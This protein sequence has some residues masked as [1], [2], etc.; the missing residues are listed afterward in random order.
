MTMGKYQKIAILTAVAIALIVIFAK[1]EFLVNKKY[2]KFQVTPNA[3]VA[4]D[5]SIQRQRPI[6]LEFYASWW[7]TCKEMEPVILALE[8]KYGDKVDFIIADV[9]QEKFL[10][11]RFDI[12]YIPGLFFIGKNG[13]VLDKE[14]GKVSQEKLEKQINN[15]LKNY[16]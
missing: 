4:L 2:E 11:Q 15:L 16:K 9:D 13:V 14:V 12:N 10:S 8:K 6:F 3:S 5:K 1:P 7:I